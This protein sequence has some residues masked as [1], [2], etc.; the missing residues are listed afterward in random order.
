MRRLLA[1]PGHIDGVLRQGAERA[2]AIA[3]P[4]LRE[5][6]EITGLLHP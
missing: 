5:V 3:Q 4:V 1:D 2:A 6:K